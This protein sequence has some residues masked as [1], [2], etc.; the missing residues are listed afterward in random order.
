[1]LPNLELVE[2]ALNYLA[3]SDADHATL[4]G[5]KDAFK[6]KIKLLKA[7]A[8]LNADGTVGPREAPADC[9]PEVEKAINDSEHCLVDFK[10]IENKRSR[11]LTTIDVWRSVSAN[12]RRS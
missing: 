5:R 2:A 7:R 4:Y 10:L 11:A 9:D 1:M 6:E 8:F 3:E 12:Q